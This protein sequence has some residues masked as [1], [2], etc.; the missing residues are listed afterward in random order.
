MYEM[1]ADFLLLSR[2]QSPSWAMFCDAQ[3]CKS[4]KSNKSVYMY[5]GTYLWSLLWF[6]H[7][8]NIDDRS[9]FSSVI[10]GTNVSNE[11]YF[12]AWGALTCFF[13]T[14]CKWQFLATP[15]HQ[16]RRFH[17]DM[18]VGL[19]NQSGSIIL[20][21]KATNSFHVTFSRL[22]NYL[23]NMFSRVIFHHSLKRRQL[24]NIFQTTVAD[25]KKFT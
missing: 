25:N 15:T 14:W 21:S 6:C 5:D 3:A 2:F 8:N 19:V 9:N 16:Q 11:S 18:N 10:D 22:W 17:N 13:T 1:T 7:A 23:E 24:P 20:L 12:I 4:I